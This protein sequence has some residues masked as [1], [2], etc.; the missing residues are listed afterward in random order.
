VDGFIY[1]LSNTA[2]NTLKIGRTSKAPDERRK[3][4]SSETGVP[5]PY[6]IEYYAF[7]EN[8]ESVERQVH[9]KLDSC[10]PQKNK[11][12]FTCSVPEAIIVIEDNANIKYKEVFYKSPEDIQREKSRQ[13]NERVL[14]EK[15]NHRKHIAQTEKEKKE[16]ELKKQQNKSEDRWNKINSYKGLLYQKLFEEI[17][18]NEL[19]KKYGL[20]TKPMSGM[21]RGGNPLFL[22]ILFYFMFA[23]F[24]LI[25]IIPN[26]TYFLLFLFVAGVVHIINH[27]KNFEFKDVHIEQIEIKIKQEIAVRCN[28][29]ANDL[30]HIGDNWEE[31]K[32]EY[33][34]QVTNE[35][36][37][38]AKQLLK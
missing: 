33:E 14:K 9:L 35:I 16:R 38:I 27:N 31:S 30:Y 26:S 24:L 1:I 15:E 25:L 8:Y 7:V 5:A 28:K 10:R 22:I 18:G 19:Q 36:R 37:E 34:A 23:P 20:S 4:L 6:K 3:E 17:F 21:G 13:E 2:F 11:E 32:F 12:H 29:I